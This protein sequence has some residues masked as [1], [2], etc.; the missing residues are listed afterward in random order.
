MLRSYKRNKEKKFELFII[1]LGIVFS[2]NV[3]GN[4]LMVGGSCE[5]SSY[6]LSI[7]V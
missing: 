5:I 7:H 6:L 2:S 1:V 4:F 3:R